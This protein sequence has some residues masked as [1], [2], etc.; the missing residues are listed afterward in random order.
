MFDGYHGWDGQAQ[1]PALWAHSQK[2]HQGL[3]AEPNARLFPQPGSN[4][5]P[6][7]SQAGML[8]ITPTVRYNSQR[9][10]ATRTIV[11]TLG[12]NTWFSLNVRE[13]SPAHPITERNGPG[14]LVQLHPRFDASG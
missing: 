13:D 6:I 7:W 8:Q 2:V 3:V 1:F 9:I 10:M 4:H 14:S 12:V 11:R 5:G